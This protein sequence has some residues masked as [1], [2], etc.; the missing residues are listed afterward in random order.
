MENE[1]TEEDVGQISDALLSSRKIEAIKI[2]REA[3][4]SGLM[5][6]KAFIEKLE[7]GLREEY[8]EKFPERGKGCAAVFL[9]GLALAT[10]GLVFVLKQNL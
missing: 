2:Y 7:D 8:P 10:T 9:I 6:A 4:G 5:E 3:T 1:L